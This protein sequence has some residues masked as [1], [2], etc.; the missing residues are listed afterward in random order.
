MNSM[1]NSDHPRFPTPT[2][3]DWKGT[4]TISVFKRKFSVSLGDL[5]RFLPY[6]Q[7][8]DGKELI[9]NIK[10][11]IKKGLITQQD[12]EIIYGKETS[13]IPNSDMPR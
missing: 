3:R 6:P 9:E 13:D 8:S 1:E 12:L 7:A 2:A 10:T 11:K 5:V 4:G